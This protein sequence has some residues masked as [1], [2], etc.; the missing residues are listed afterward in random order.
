M[1]FKGCSSEHADTESISF[2][3][4]LKLNSSKKLLEKC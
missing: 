3:T 4:T 2:Y 1:E